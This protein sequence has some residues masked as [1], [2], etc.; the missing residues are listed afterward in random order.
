MIYLI[1][2]K[3]FYLQ[4]FGETV[5]KL[6][7]RFNWHRTEFNH[8]QQYDHCHILIDHFN[9]ELVKFLSC[10]VQ[11]LKTNKYIETTERGTRD[12]SESFVKAEKRSVC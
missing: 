7:C 10:S 12:A 8:P 4:Y 3:K 9:E 11:I 6:N 1:T 2:C 5:L